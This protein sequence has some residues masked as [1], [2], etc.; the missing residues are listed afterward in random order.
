VAGKT[1][2]VMTMVLRPGE[3]VDDLL[4]SQSGGCPRCGG[5]LRRWGHGRW[6]VVRDGKGEWGF[7]PGRLRCADCRVTQVVLPA[8]V[9]VRRRDSVAVVGR[10]WRAFAGG[11]GARQV[12]RRLAVPL[13][14]VR[15]WQ[16]RLRELA[17]LLYGPARPG[18][19][20]PLRLALE[21]VVAQARLVGWGGQGDSWR[22]VAYWSQ[23]RLLSGTGF[24]NTS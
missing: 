1:G 16:R 23:G 4:G 10:A 6:R 21:H 19:R 15:G 11:A 17:R 3:S 24:L 2:G 7:R 22:F 8:E 18:Q 20:S 9:L 5:P 13:E 12:A 14:T